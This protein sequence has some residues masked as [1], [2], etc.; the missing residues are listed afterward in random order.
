MGVLYLWWGECHAHIKLST[1]LITAN[2]AK[3]NIVITQLIKSKIGISTRS[4]FVR[5]TSSLSLSL[6]LSL[7]LSLAL[8]LFFSTSLAS[9][10]SIL[11]TQRKI[12]REDELDIHTYMDTLIDVV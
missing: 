11:D 1:P 5:S 12:E 7:T 6:S 10:V 8:S 3:Q 2:F 4:H 9:H